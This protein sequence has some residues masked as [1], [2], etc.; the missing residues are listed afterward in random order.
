M[1]R[2]EKKGIEVEPA[3][4]MMAFRYALG[5]QTYAPTMIAEEIRCNMRKLSTDYLGIMADQI[6]HEYEYDGLG[7]DCDVRTWMELQRDIE[8]ELGRREHERR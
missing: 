6:Q 5:R 2:Y 3:T 8:K 1:F 7:E 4:L